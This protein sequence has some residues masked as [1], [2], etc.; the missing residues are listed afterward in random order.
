MLE[1]KILFFDFFLMQCKL[2]WIKVSAKCIYIKY[3]V[4]TYK[5]YNCCLLLDKRI[6]NQNEPFTFLMHVVIFVRVLSLRSSLF[7]V[8]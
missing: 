3:V 2:L 7:M 8:L 1:L 6:Y 5:I 4:Y